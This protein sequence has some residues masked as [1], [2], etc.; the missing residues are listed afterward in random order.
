MSFEIALSGI[1]AINTQLD[2]ISNNIANSGTYGFKSSRANFASMYA[3]TQPT[4]TEVSS[5]TQTLGIGGG[6]LNTGRDLDVSISGGGFF[7]T[8]DTDGTE[9]YT[10]VGVFSKD[11]DGYLVDSFGRKVQGYAA[12]E[13]SDALGAMGNLQIPTGQ[14]PAQASTTLN[15]VGNLSVDWTVPTVATFDPADPQS[16]NSS[17]LSVVHDS[18][19]VKHT[20]TQYFVKTDTNEI[21]AYYTFD[22]GAPVGSQVLSFDTEGRLQS[23]TAAVTVNLGTPTGAEPMTLALDYT[24]TTQYGG[25]ATTTTNAANGYAAGTQSGVQIDADG[26]VFAT[27]SNGE[28]LK[29]GTLVLATFPNQDA[30]VP[31][32]D[33]SW[34]TSNASGLPLYST[35]GVGLAGSL[36]AGALE[37]SNVDMTS[38]LVTL[39]SAQRNYQAN[40]KVISTENEMMQTLMQ[41]L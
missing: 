40:T 7:V 5:L 9:V 32:S 37:Q 20:V 3:G 10:R 6:V 18:L 8:R 35:P 27:Y 22:G 24:G 17:V 26:S 25:D 23:P 30:L 14:I 12:V 39:M 28:K 11:K 38:E 29:V 16:F 15:Y 13:G 19:G 33:T 21:T 41:A 4:G 2:T 36:T 31:I 34:T 1:N